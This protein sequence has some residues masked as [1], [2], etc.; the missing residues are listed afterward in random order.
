[1]ATPYA[2]LDDLAERFPRALTSA[3]EERAETLL[4]DAS[5]W[6]G[7]WVPGLAESADVTVRAAAK[8]IVVEMV[9]RALVAQDRPDGA[10]SLSLTAGIYAQSI[11]FRNPDGN[12]FLYGRE[13]D[14]LEGLL[15]GSRAS[16]VSI[17]SPGL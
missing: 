14:D 13:L 7:V 5:F 4:G 17:R 16:A 3:E 2:S 1:M 9:K 8:L 15:R 12:L 10:E 6:L 11:R